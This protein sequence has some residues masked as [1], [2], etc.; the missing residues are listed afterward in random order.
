MIFYVFFN[1][2]DK[3]SK[4]EKAAVDI[5]FFRYICVV[6]S[7]FMQIF[8]LRCCRLLICYIMYNYSRSRFL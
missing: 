6:V 8:L 3:A 1:A 5:V 7:Y 4:K 2:Q